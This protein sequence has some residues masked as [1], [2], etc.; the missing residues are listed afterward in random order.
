[1]SYRLSSSA[2]LLFK[3]GGIVP[4]SWVLEIV[5][6]ELVLRHLGLYKVVRRAQVQLVGKLPVIGE[7]VIELELSAQAWKVSIH[8]LGHIMELAR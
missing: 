7:E 6:A 8:I 2:K 4:E 5:L 1:M 3:P